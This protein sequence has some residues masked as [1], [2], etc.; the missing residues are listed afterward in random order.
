MGGLVGLCLLF[1]DE[2]TLPSRA[3][4]AA[5]VGR[6]AGTR[7]TRSLPMLSVFQSWASSEPLFSPVATCEPAV[8]KARLENGLMRR[9]APASGVMVQC[10]AALLSSRREADHLLLLVVAHGLAGIRSGNDVVER[11]T[12]ELRQGSGR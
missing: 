3:M 5:T 7:M 10:C 9:H 6:L 12:G 1:G 2:R 8:R 11:T 4:A